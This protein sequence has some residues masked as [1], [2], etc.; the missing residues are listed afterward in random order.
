MSESIKSDR[1][2]NS[3]VARMAGNIAGSLVPSTAVSYPLGDELVAS[4]ATES[5][6]LARAIAAEVER[7]QVC[8][9]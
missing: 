6:R 3:S 1:I 8:K 4:I 9:T 7:T 5:V 2:S